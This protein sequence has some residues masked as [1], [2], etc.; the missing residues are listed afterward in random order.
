MANP[1]KS[2]PRAWAGGGV[3]VQTNDLA[4]DV[5]TSAKL[6]PTTIQTA[7]VSLTNAEIKAL[8][9]SPKTL[10]PAPGAGYLLEFICATLLLDYGSNGLTESA[11]N[12]GVRYGDGSGTQISETIEATGFIDATA[13]TMTTARVKQDGIVA[14]SACE[15]KALVLH[16]LGD[17]EFG[18]NAGADTV[19]RVKIAYRVW[20]TGW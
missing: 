6:D 19:M 2:V 7:T 13:D 18:G 11:D 9:A 10:V 16:N 5:V 4:D 3:E 17:G 12:L 15:N 1:L 8:R 20:P 14:K